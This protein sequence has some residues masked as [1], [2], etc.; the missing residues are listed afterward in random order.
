LSVGAADYLIAPFSIDGSTVYFWDGATVAYKVSVSGTTLSSFTALS[1]AGGGNQNPITLGSYY[2]SFYAPN[3]Y[4]I[5]YTS[6]G[7]FNYGSF[8]TSTSGTYNG[9][10]TLDSTTIAAS[11][12]TT[13]GGY[14]AIALLKVLI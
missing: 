4:L 8:V 1:N 5:T 12:T 11:L 14:I 7:V 13:V 2:A 9:I 10:S 3:I 6:T